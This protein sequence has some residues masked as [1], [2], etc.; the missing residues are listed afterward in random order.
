MDDVLLWN[1]RDEVTESTIANLVAEIDNSW[2]TPP[3]SCGL[4]PASSA[5]HCSMRARCRSA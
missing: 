3:L 1:E 2:W 5:R 4:L